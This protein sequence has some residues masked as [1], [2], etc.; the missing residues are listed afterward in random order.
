MPK[1]LRT[2]KG[3]RPRKA[4]RPSK[5]Q[6]T[7]E[8]QLRRILA[9]GGTPQ[10]V[11]DQ[12]TGELMGY[13]DT[14]NIPESQKHLTVTSNGS[15]PL[16]ALKARGM[17]SEEAH[18]AASY[19]AAL[20]KMAFGKACPS[21]I[22][23]NA[24]GGSADEYEHEKAAERQRRYKD[25]AAAMQR[26]SRH[27]FDAVE[28]LVVFERWPDWMFGRGSRH[29]KFRHQFGLGMAALLAWYTGDRRAARAAAA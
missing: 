11:H 20:R 28:N 29:N 24:S 9:I 1:K 4:P 2:R 8:T 16:D 18:M 23:L 19:Y 5:D 15:C 13:V 7:P 6:G 10:A 25:A 12:V 22:D 27:A 21:A 17:I 3:G 14:R 26:A